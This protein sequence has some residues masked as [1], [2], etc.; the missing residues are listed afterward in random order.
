[1]DLNKKTEKHR[2]FCLTV[3]IWN[4]IFCF[5]F[6][7]KKIF[8][9]TYIESPYYP[10][11]HTP[12]SSILYQILCKIKKQTIDQEFRPNTKYVNDNKCRRVDSPQRQTTRSQSKYGEQIKMAC[13]TPKNVAKVGAAR[14]GHAE[15]LWPS[16]SRRVVG[17]SAGL[18]GR[19]KCPAR[20]S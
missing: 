15:C 19:G 12:I 1:M 17:F 20:K 16:C 11:T 4:S 9:F 2:I 13:R 6:L 5:F 7:F 18:A 10:H 3:Y 8:L 14:F